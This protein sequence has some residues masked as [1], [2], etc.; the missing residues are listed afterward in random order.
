MAGKGGIMMRFDRTRAWA[1]AVTLLLVAHI[2]M[3]DSAKYP[4]TGL[5]KS[6]S[7]S[8]T[9]T[10]SVTVLYAATEPST[11]TGSNKVFVLTQ[12]CFLVTNFLPSGNTVT[13][14]AGSLVLPFAYANANGG[15]YCHSFTP[16]Y[17]VPEGTDVTC[18]A[19][20]YD[21]T[22]NAFTCTVSGIVAK[23]K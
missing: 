21:S 5:I 4:L 3:A 1:T 8:G 9:G 16:G 14:T 11:A 2:S 22:S 10:S 17:V 13:L 12:V 15:T 6:G 18:A 7:G 20:A 19:T 23:L